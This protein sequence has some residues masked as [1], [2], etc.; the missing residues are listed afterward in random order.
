MKIQKIIITSLIAILGLSTGCDQ[1]SKQKKEEPNS[2]TAIESTPKPAATASHPGKKV[3]DSTCLVCHMANGKGVPGM[4]PPLVET[5]WVTGDKDRL[6]RITIQGLSGKIEVNGVTY[7]SIMPPNPHLSDQE[8]ADVLTYI[9]QN[10][11]NDADEVTIDEVKEVR[12][13]L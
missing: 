7:N 9:R 8:V 6:I 3:Y 4:F 10:F 13:N 2:D 11:G 1:S 12:N 5:D